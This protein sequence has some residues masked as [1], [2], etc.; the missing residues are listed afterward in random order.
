MIDFGHTTG[1]SQAPLRGVPAWELRGF[2][3]PMRDD[4]LVTPLQEFGHRV[5]MRARAALG[6]HR[7][8]VLPHGHG[9]EGQAIGSPSRGAEAV[10]RLLGLPERPPSLPE[11]RHKKA[12]R[13][14]A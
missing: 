6:V 5:P 4:G 13:S 10:G 12:I 3:V 1:F 8:V 11:K 2:L 7:H 9:P 14:D